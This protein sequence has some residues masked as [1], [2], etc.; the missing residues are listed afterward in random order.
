MNGT[1]EQGPPLTKPR[2]TSRVSWALQGSI[3]RVRGGMKVA[4]TRLE[5]RLRKRNRG[6]K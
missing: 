6:E 2:K 4:T 5:M 1:V 3:R